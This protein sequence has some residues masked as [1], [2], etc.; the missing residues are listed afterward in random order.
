M[1]FTN[2]NSPKWIT[3]KGA[4]GILLLRE[5]I[6]QEDGKNPLFQISLN[7]LTKT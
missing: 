3:A 7:S 5:V 1:K 2:I 4:L 6:L